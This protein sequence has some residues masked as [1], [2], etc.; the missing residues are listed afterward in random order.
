MDYFH[1][2]E[3]DSSGLHFA[4]L[5]LDNLGIAHQSQA[6]DFAAGVKLQTQW[7]QITRSNLTVCESYHHRHQAMHP[8]PT[9]RQQ[10]PGALFGAGH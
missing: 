1:Q 3:Y 10:Q 7:L 4:G 8:R 6:G 5:L 9:T 2:I